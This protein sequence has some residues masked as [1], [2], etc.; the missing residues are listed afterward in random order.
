MIYIIDGQEVSEEQAMQQA[1]A[2]GLDFNTYLSAVGA[3]LKQGTGESTEQASTQPSA[4]SQIIDGKSPED[5]LEV[6]ATEDVPAVTGTEDA[7]KPLEEMPTSELELQ[8]E[9]TSL[10]IA[11]IEKDLDDFKIAESKKIKGVDPKGEFNRPGWY[12]ELQKLK[13]KKD[14]VSNQ[15]QVRYTNA[16]KIDF[17][18]PEFVANQLEDRVI[19]EMRAEH[20][21]PYLNVEATG[22]GNEIVIKNYLGTG[23]DVNVK[24]D[25]SEESKKVF[26]DLNDYDKALTDSSRVALTLESSLNRSF[27]NNDVI[28][29]NKV[30]KSSGY[31]IQQVKTP[32][33]S[34]TTGYDSFGVPITDYTPATYEYSL[35][36][37]GVIIASDMKAI[38]DILK[39]DKKL[40][41]AIVQ[42]AYDIQT[43]RVEKRA[44]ALEKEKEIITKDPTTTVDYYED[45]SFEKDII[46]A[47]QDKG[48][49]LSPEEIQTVQEY[50]KSINAR[51]GGVEVQEGSVM[52]QF[53]SLLRMADRMGF[54]DESSSK[55]YISDKEKVEIYRNLSGL[56]LEVI[57]K[58]KA[59]GF[60]PTVK[61]KVAE[62]AYQKTLEKSETIFED[63]IKAEGNQETIQTAQRFIGADVKDTTV[64]LEKRA[65]KVVEQREKQATVF[66]LQAQN[67][68]ENI[69]PEGARIGLMAAGGS[70]QLGLQIDRKLTKE[71]QK[72]FDKA[73]DMLMDLQYSLDLSQRDYVNTINNIQKDFQI[74]AANNKGVDQGL[75]NTASKEYG[76]NNLLVKDV[77]DSFASLLLSVP[78]LLDSDWANLEQ[79][80]INR[81]NN[82]YET[83]R[84]YDDGDFGRYVLR[85]TAQQSANIVTAIATGGAASGLG[86]GRM[87]SQLAIGTVFGVSSG[88]QTFRD[89]SS[90]NTIYDLAKLRGEQATRAKAEG[91]ISD[92]AYTQIMQDV[93]NTLAMGRLSNTQVMGA[94]FTNGVIEGSVMTL[95]GQAPNTLKL[96]KDFRAPTQ[97]AEISKNLFSKY[98]KV[99]QLYNYIGK[100][101]V[102]RPL[103]E[104][105]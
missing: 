8:L 5:F 49:D 3:V 15:L 4:F 22:A 70:S 42:E 76:L 35:T 25:G 62:I 82:Y 85:T 101:L 86:L 23:K 45:G 28:P 52:A 96:L 26:K 21:Y 104:V 36:K 89:L 24:L 98:G 2:M 61:K 31:E 18:N 90:Q 74:Y 81:K 100:P 50:F 48:L 95:I 43:Q 27:K 94:S 20:G 14:E 66:S 103:G 53:P 102:T 9:E 67:I 105:V 99:G 69:A 30:I 78:T 33:K 71:E 32:G 80:K 64:A 12:T 39:G 10:A 63:L 40:E 92:Y 38:S 55:N 91:I 34:I 54:V 75:F 79:Q 84:A 51:V 72:Q 65:D 77:N 1:K 87:A 37:D 16:D 7:S 13:R 11:E 58:I 60:L 17:S 19:T 93:N 57:E 88:T 41:G 46:K 29:L 68:I 59:S 83:A 97:M 47:I 44:Q 56:P 73:S 6:A